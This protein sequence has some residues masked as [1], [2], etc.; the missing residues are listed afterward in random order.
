MKKTETWKSNLEVSAI[1]AVASQ[2]AQFLV[3]KETFYV[4]S[5]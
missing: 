3:I 4:Q 1:V 2:P 5:M